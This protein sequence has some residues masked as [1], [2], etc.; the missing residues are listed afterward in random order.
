MNKASLMHCSL[1]SSSEITFSFSLVI[2]FRKLIH[3]TVGC[4]MKD[5]RIFLLFF[6]FVSDAK[7]VLLVTQLIKRMR[8]ERHLVRKPHE[9]KKETEKHGDR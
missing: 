9:N 7:S 4:T 8:N 5:I 6:S 1:E 2:L 3:G